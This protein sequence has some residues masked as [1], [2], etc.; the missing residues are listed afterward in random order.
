MTDIAKGD[1][2]PAAIDAVVSVTIRAKVIRSDED[3]LGDRRITPRVGPSWWCRGARG[4]IE[5]QE[6][7]PI[8]RLDRHVST[9]KKRKSDFRYSFPFSLRGKGEGRGTKE[10]GRAW[11]RGCAPLHTPP[12]AHG[13]PPPFEQ[14]VRYNYE[15]THLFVSLAEGTLLERLTDIF[16][17]AREEPGTESGVVHE[18][19]FSGRWLDDDHA[20]R[21]EEIARPETAI[22]DRRRRVLRVGPSSSHPGSG[23]GTLWAK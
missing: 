15:K 20:R 21:K 9:P 22:R 3:G 23:S 4:E 13:T 16:T 12:P 17:P 18:D 14:K 19:N 1:V 7:D 2:L 6:F 5:W 11:A 8:S 10:G